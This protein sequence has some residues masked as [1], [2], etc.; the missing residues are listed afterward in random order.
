MRDLWY[1]T[2]VIYELDVETFADG[3]GDGVGDFVGLTS[4]LP[5][6]AGLG[7]T[8]VWLMPFYPTPNRDD[9]YDVTDYYGVDPRLG[10]LGDFVQFT[11]EAESH[12]LR[13]IVD[14]V[15]NHTSDQHPWFKSA[16]RSRRSPFRDWYVWSK[17]RPPDYDKGTVFPGYQDAIWSYDRRAQAYYYHRFYD[18]QPD[19]NVANPAVR[20]ELERVMGFWLQLGV[21]GFRVDAAPFLIEHVDVPGQPPA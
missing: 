21:A 15:I 14:L 7:A 4:R 1:K 10:T 18:F 20:E 3:N 13:V 8:C 19:L 17:T 5:S 16:R 9:G 12:G 11:H 6:I 2:A